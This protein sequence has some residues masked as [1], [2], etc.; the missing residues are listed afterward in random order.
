MRIFQNFG[1]YPSYRKRLDCLAK[2]STT[3]AHRLD[4]FLDDRFGACHLLQPVLER[5]T[6][7]FF[8]NGDDEILQHLWA[9]EQGMPKKSKLEAILFAQIE[10]H[11]TEVFYNLD[12]MRY[13]SDFIRRLPGCVKKSIAWRSAPSPG[14]D[15]AA[16]DLIVCNFPS[17]IESYKK[18]GWRATYFSPG[19]DPV[20]DTYANNRDRP[21]DVIFAGGYSRH[22]LRRAMLLET[23]AALSQNLNVAMHLDCSRLNHF[24]E[25]PIVKRLPFAKKH[26]RPDVLAGIAQPALFGRDL[27]KAIGQSKI[28]L[29]GA[30]DMAGSYRGNMRCF[31]S[32]GCGALMLS[33]DG[34]YP[35]GMVDG[36]T[37]LT[38]NKPDDA[39]LLI[40]KY[41]GDPERLTIAQ[42]GCQVVRENYSK[43]AQWNNFKVLVEG[44]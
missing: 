8:T 23:V 13:T 20:M 18:N 38:Y 3:F 5:S 11:Q 35:P 16:Y 32:M 41:L 34:N 22:H 40:K 31:E 26:R 9:I 43:Q 44:A 36:E 14:A 15:F 17:I 12:P 19:H 2:T 6:T 4:F 27:Y 7:A 1:L 24:A 25:L 21:I 37:M 30:V 29:N 42:N 10:H 33:D 28:V 39:I